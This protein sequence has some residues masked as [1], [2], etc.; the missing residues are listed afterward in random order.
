MSV[1]YSQIFNVISLEYIPCIRS[2]LKTLLHNSI[3]MPKLRTTAIP[4]YLRKWMGGVMGG[5][6]RDDNRNIILR[7]LS[8]DPIGD[9]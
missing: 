4:K 3:M 1:S 2:A 5:K 9:K 7:I 6:F 8:F